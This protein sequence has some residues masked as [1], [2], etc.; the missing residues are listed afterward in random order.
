MWVG[1]ILAAG[2]LLSEPRVVDGDTLR[3][4]RGEYYRVENLDAPELGRRARCPAELALAEAARDE[5]RRL[6]AT[7]TR[8]EAVETGRRDRYDRNLARIEIDG[9]DLG[10]TLIAQGL[11]RPWRGRSSNF[12]ETP[13]ASRSTTPQRP[14]RSMAA[15]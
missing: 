5:A 15:R 12:C 8:V 9:R 7:A 13:T 4:G 1:L 14:V 2:V 3:D 10:E 11:A 6:V